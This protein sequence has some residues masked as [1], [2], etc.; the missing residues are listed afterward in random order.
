[1]T[2]RRPTVIRPVPDWAVDASAAATYTYT[3]FGGTLRSELPFAEL[4]EAPKGLLHDW[5]LRVATHE[6]RDEPT[7]PLGTRRVGSETYGL[8]ATRSGL[9]LE[10]SHAG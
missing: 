6:S 2:T 1:M 3:V 5:T 9:R 7:L 10:Y 8:A 4:P